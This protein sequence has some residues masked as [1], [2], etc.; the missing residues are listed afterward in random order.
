MPQNR[1]DEAMDVDH[2]HC[3]ECR[4]IYR[5]LLAVRVAFR[6]ALLRYSAVTQG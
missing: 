2:S 5:D 4:A 1:Y 6:G 3:A